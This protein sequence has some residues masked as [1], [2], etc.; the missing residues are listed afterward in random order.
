MHSNTQI[1][2]AA[3]LLTSI[4]S[5]SAFAELSVPAGLSPGDS[6]QLI[7]NSSTFTQ[8]LSSNIN[9]Y[10]N[11]SQ[12]AADAAG[13][14]ASEGIAWRAVASTASIDAR[15]NAVVGANT[16]EYNTHTGPLEK[17][18]DGFSDMWDGSIDGF[19]ACDEF[20]QQNFV[21]PWTGTLSSGLRATGSTLGH[22]SGT[23]WC[24][25]PSLVNSQ[26][27]TFIE[28]STTTLL[29]IYALSE[30]LTVTDAD[31]DQDDDINGRDYFAWQRGKGGPA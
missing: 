31:F 22:S 20:G 12:S 18:A 5:C 9:F 25:R 29:A 21:D 6:Y 11:F 15:V 19:P 14:G 1:F 24:G 13:I 16:P 28:P 3:L 26:W 27:I 8:A 10:N 30:V 23:A 2:A 4:A 7:F 17:I